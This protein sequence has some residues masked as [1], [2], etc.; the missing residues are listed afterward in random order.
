MDELRDFPIPPIT[1][2]TFVENSMK[3][4]MYQN[5]SLIIHV[6]VRLLKNDAMNYVNITILDNGKGFP[7]EEPEPP[8]FGADRGRLAACGNQQC[9]A[10]LLYSI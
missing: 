9:E 6:K 8:E 1:I 2:L 3:F 4:G 10:P 5:K 7:E